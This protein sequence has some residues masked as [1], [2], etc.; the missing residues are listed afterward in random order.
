MSS[1]KWALVTILMLTVSVVGWYVL[2][3]T[4]PDTTMKTETKQGLVDD[5]PDRPE[6]PPAVPTLSLGPITVDYSASFAIFTRGTFRDFA[7]EMYHNLSEYVYIEAINPNIVRVKKANTTWDDFFKTLPFKLTNECLTTG[8]KQ[9]F[10]TNDKEKLK[11]YLNGR[12][13]QGALDRVINLGDE[14]LISYGDES[15]AEI[16]RQLQRV[17]AVQ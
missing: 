5:L 11:F 14:L 4:K 13:D 17:P 9:T 3:S 16:S 7:A 8:T 6:Q 10:C 1:S 12:Q 2:T 15:G